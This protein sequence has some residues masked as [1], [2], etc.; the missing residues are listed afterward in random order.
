MD[1]SPTRRRIWAARGL[2]VVADL[3]QLGL[4]PLF[5]GGAL[6]GVD[7]AVDVAMAAI[8]TSLVGWH[9][10]FLPAF[11]AELLPVVGLVPSW[12]L[13]VFIATRDRKAPDGPPDQGRVI[14]VEPIHRS[15][16]NSS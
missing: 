15:P 1:R 4:T 2:A 9:W 10:A 14:D 13:A 5:F 7:A 12:T 16:E 8:L 6:T 11:V 3:I